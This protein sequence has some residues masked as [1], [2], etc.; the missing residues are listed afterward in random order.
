MKSFRTFLAEMKFPGAYYNADGEQYPVVSFN[1]KAEKDAFDAE[2]P[3]A[4]LI[5][6]CDNDAKKDVRNIAKHQQAVLNTKTDSNKPADLIS[7]ATTLLNN[8][9]KDLSSLRNHNK[10]M[11]TLSSKIGNKLSSVKDKKIYDTLLKQ[12]KALDA[13]I[14]KNRPQIDNYERTNY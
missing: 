1:S 8:I 12:K 9:P 4:D 6:K 3:D 14:D 11:T 5:Y 2:N 7:N 13:A 10:D